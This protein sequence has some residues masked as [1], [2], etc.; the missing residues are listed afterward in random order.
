MCET[1]KSCVGRLSLC[2][3]PL[4]RTKL[5][6]NSLVNNCYSRFLVSKIPATATA[7]KTLP[8]RAVHNANQVSALSWKSLLYS[9]PLWTLALLP[10]FGGASYSWIRISSVRIVHVKNL[11]FKDNGFS[12]NYARFSYSFQCFNATA[13]E[14]FISY[15]T[16]RDEP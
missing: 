9:R 8:S 2:H 15:T 14:K 5:S 16:L 4:H 1:K 6:T 11:S 7:T 13:T 12:D 10:N 3:L